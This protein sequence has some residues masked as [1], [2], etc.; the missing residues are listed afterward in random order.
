MSTV[1]QIHP[2]NPQPRLVRQ[3]V[4]EIARGG[5]VVYPTD[6]CY[7]IGCRLGNKKGVERIRQLRGLREDHHLTLLC[8][9]V[10]EISAYA[11][12]TNRDFRLLKE[13]TPGPYTFIL[14]ASREVPRRLQHPK[15]RSIGIRIPGDP[16]CQALIEA[17]GEPL[18]SSS[19]ILPGEQQP[20]TD[21]NEIIDRLDRQVDVIIDGGEGRLQPSTVIDLSGEAPV[22]VREGQGEVPADVERP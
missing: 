18:M 7:A 22:L 1:L 9:D 10:S 16:I 21:P 6:S 8:R 11:Q 2:D 12:F 17:L 3:A 4:A 5:V 13:R 19:L 14:P 20:L 15:R